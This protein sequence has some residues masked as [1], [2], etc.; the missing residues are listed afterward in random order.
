MAFPFTEDHEMIREAARGFL[1]DWFDGGKGLEKIYQS[2]QA[3]DAQAW[4]SFAAEQGMAGIAIDQEYGGAGLGDLGRV[5]VMEELGASLCAIPFL[6]T[7][8]IVA[9]IIKIAGEDSA[10]AD[11]LPKIASGELTASYSDGHDATKKVVTHSVYSGH[12]DMII[13]SRRVADGIDYFAINSD[14]EGLVITLEKTMDPTRSF[15]KVDWSEVADSDMQIIGYGSEERHAKII[16]QSFIALAAECVGGAQKCLDMTLEYAGQRVQ[17]DRPIASFQ[18]IKHRCADM[19]ILIEAARSATYAAAI[20]SPEEKTEAALIA[21]AYAVDAFFKV[22]GDA[23][24]MHGGIGF[25]WEY[26]LHFFFKRARA[27]RSMFGSSSRDY[28]RLADHIF[29]DAA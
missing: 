20:A 21:K 6:T 24:Q 25:T 18:A 3:F 16:T 5:V 9:D 4:K 26:P 27:N 17:F 29:G 15:A 19:F 12:T 14:A 13:L 10:K 8:G 28:D 22:S 11:L 2:G 23:I 7:C 1:Q